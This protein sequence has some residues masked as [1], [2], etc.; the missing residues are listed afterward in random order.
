MRAAGRSL[1]PGPAPPGV[2]AAGACWVSST[3]QGEDAA[4]LAGVEGVPGFGTSGVTSL[5]L[6]FPA[7][8]FG[9]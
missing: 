9:L 5:A 8:A 3:L 1:R 6:P 2:G 7:L 4:P